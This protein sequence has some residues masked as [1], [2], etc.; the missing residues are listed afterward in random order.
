MT[1]G[2]VSVIW[3][4]TSI[5]TVCVCVKIGQI[6]RG[7]RLKPPGI[8]LGYLSNV[9]SVKIQRGVLLGQKYRDEVEEESV[10]EH[11]IA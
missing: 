3:D 5:I 4:A 10:T 11:I 1:L 2:E 9:R 7:T 6:S 8:G